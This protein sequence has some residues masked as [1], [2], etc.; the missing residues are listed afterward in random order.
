D[1]EESAIRAVFEWAEGDCELKIELTGGSA[2]APTQPAQP[3]AHAVVPTQAAATPASPGQSASI[4]P[5]STP[6]AHPAPVAAAV[7]TSTATPAPA[8]VKL[9][10]VPKTDAPME[11]MADSGS[12]RV[13]VEKIDELMNT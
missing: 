1:V 5:A 4:A 13:S 3:Q 11:K 6:S 2:S 12:I 10:A 9:E 7:P 8:P